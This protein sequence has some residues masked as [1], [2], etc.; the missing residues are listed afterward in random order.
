[1]STSA[2][3]FDTLSVTGA[4]GSDLIEQTGGV[5]PVEDDGYE[6][7][8]ALSQR[9]SQLLSKDTISPEEFTR[10]RDQLRAEARSRNYDL[11]HQAQMADEVA[12]GTTVRV[13]FHDDEPKITIATSVTEALEG[14]ERIARDCQA[15][16]ITRI[17]PSV[18]SCTFL[19]AEHQEEAGNEMFGFWTSSTSVTTFKGGP[20]PYVAN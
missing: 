7:F 6:G 14:A 8:L 12:D 5:S 18:I 10:L 9:L 13:E 20:I 11:V 15:T 3:D 17:S 16:S 1:M 2:I 4:D 19:S